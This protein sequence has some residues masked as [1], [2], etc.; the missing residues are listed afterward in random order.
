M[1]YVFPYARATCGGTAYFKP[2][3]LLFPFASVACG[4]TACCIISSCSFLL[5][6]PH[7]VAQ[8]ASLSNLA[9]LLFPYASTT[10]G[11]TACFII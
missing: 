3:P 7:A 5:L 9:L 1:S 4:K 2:Y 11:R 8:P 10:C 6:A